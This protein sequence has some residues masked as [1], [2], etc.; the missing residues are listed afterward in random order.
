MV[1]AERAERDAGDERD[2]RDVR[3][4]F[5]RNPYRRGAAGDSPVVDRVDEALFFIFVTPAT[6]SSEARDWTRAV[7]WR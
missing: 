1:R 6:P 7:S 2:E 5:W 3:A 4:G